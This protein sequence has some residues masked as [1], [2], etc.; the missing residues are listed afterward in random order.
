MSLKGFPLPSLRRE[1]A[2]VMDGTRCQVHA[3]NEYGTNFAC[4][5][6]LLSFLA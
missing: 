1:F 5:V 2:A 3:P 6:A 4:K